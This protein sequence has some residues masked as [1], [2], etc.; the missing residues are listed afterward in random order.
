MSGMSSHQK[1]GQGEKIW[2]TPP[3]IIEALGPFDLDPCFMIDRPW[4]TAK[5]HYTPES[6]DGLGGLFGPWF[7]RVWCNPPYDNKAWDWLSKC[8]DHG[9]AIALTFARTEVK[10]FHRQV[11]ERAHACLFLEGRLFFHTP[12]GARAKNNGGAPS[13]LV[14]YGLGASNTL[15]NCGLKGHF[16]RLWG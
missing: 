6:N 12:D 2:L 11:W 13:V 3:E 14:A 9:N 5:N 15:E 7:G 1:H 4:D 8:A 10:Q 16:V